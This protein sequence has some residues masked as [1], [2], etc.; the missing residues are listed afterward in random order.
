MTL[1]AGGKVRIVVGHE[2]DDPTIVLTL[3]DGMVMCESVAGWSAGVV[4]PMCSI[5]SDYFDESI[6]KH[7]ENGVV[8]LEQHQ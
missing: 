8:M 7:T 3:D 6:A 2:E 1:R 5:G 4:E